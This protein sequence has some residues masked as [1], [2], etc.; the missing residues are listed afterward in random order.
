MTAAAAPE[1]IPTSSLAAPAEARTQLG[2]SLASLAPGHSTRVV[3]VESSCPK[4]ERLLDLG[5]IPGTQVEILKRAPLGD[6]VIYGLRGYRI[7]LRASEAKL[8]RVRTE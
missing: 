1:L 5:F 8:I 6:P 4:G 7:C 2:V 3:G